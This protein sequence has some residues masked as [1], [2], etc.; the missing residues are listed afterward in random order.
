MKVSKSILFTGILLAPLSGACNSSTNG[1]DVPSD[2]AAANLEPSVDTPTPPT[3]VPPGPGS[4][5]ASEPVAGTPAPDPAPKVPDVVDPAPVPMTPVPMPM[6]TPAPME[7]LAASC[8]D[9]K[10]ATPAAASG[11][12]KIHLTLPGE[13][14]KTAVDAYCGMEED[15]GGW[16]LILS[17]THK[18]GTNPALAVMTK[19]LPLFGADTLGADD[20][21]KA[22]VW[23]HASNAMLSSLPF[24][25]M[26][27]FCKSSTNAKVIHFKSS[28]ATC[29]AAMTTGKGHCRNV[30]TGFTALSSH[31]AG[32]PANIDTSDENKADATLVDNTF[33]HVIADGPDVMWNIRADTNMKSWECDSAVDAET[34]NTIHRIWVR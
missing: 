8:A 13:T 23:G 19:T 15:A 34:A 33:G 28:D 4:A 6:P 18:G 14:V 12:Y 16:T 20:S 11:V 10:K 7:V 24:S 27:F 3:I 1:P 26:R 31:S 22:S 9:I 29:K 21:V 17:Y 32:L 30:K 5:P 2:P 25:E